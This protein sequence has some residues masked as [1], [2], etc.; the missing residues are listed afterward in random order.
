MY[1]QDRTQSLD[2]SQT[3]LNLRQRWAELPILYTYWSGSIEQDPGCGSVKDCPK[4]EARMGTVTYPVYLLIWEYWAG[5]RLWIRQGLSQR[6]GKG[7]HSYHFLYTYWSCIKQDPVSGS[8][9]N[10]PHAKARVGSR[11]AP[12]TYPVYLLIWEYWAVPDLWIHPEL[13][14][15]RG[16]G[17]QQ[18]G[19]SYLSC[20]LTDLGVL[21]RTR[22]LDPSQTVPK[23]RQRWAQLPILCTHWSGSMEQDPISGSIP[24]CPQAEARVCSRLGTVTYP[25]YL[26]IWK[27]WAGPNLWIHPKLSPSWGKG[28]QQAGH[29]YLS[30]VLTDLEVWSRTRS[31]DPSQTVP[32]LRQGWAAGWQNHLSRCP[33]LEGAGGGNCRTYVK[34]FLNSLVRVA[35]YSNCQLELQSS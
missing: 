34:Y 23:L 32:K 18:A 2:P 9:P 10:C 20:I 17:G 15:S 14:P 8:I 1:F 3:V 6:W 19:I 12:A 24:S 35:I 31:Q 22:S 7:G 27:Y 5:P 11:L 4:D 16:K 33:A 29:S 28:G 13:S 30:C 25:I 26:L 21:S